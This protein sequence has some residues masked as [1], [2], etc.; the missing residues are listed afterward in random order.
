[1]L[2]DFVKENADDMN[3]PVYGKLK[4]SLKDNNRS[5]SAGKSKSANRSKSQT[6]NFSS[7]VKVAQYHRVYSCIL[8]KGEHRLL[9]YYDAFKRLKPHE[10]LKFVRDNRLR[11]NCLMPIHQAAACRR[12]TV[13]KDVAKSIQNS[14]T[15]Q[16]VRILYREV[17]IVNHL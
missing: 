15:F 12:Q 4:S 7:G 2:V 5:G 14:F 1:M 13:C 6:T 10:R 11:D 8:C 16:V 17:Q 9:F 3:D